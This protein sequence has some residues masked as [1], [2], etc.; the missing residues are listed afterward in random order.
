MFEGRLGA[1]SLNLK[2]LRLAS[3]GLEGLA[4]TA[5]LALGLWVQKSRGGRGERAC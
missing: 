3:V 2:V 4:F 5:F 1:R